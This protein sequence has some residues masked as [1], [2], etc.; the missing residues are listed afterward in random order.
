M[1]DISDRL[2]AEYA[3]LSPEAKAQLFLSNR[4]GTYAG[5]EVIAL[6]HPQAFPET[7]PQIMDGQ[8][9]F[10]SKKYFTKDLLSV[11]I[12]E[13]EQDGVPLTYVLIDVDKLKKIN[14]NLGH[15]A[16]HKVID[17][18]INLLTKSFRS[19]DRR[20]TVQQT[21]IEQRQ[22]PARK[23]P[24]KPDTIAQIPEYVDSGRVGFGDE[25]ALILYNADINSAKNAMRRFQ[26][27]L[28][29]LND[30]REVPFTV[31][32]GIAQYTSGAIPEQLI[33]Y[34]DQALYM[35]KKT[36]RNRVVIFGENPLRDLTRSQR[37][38]YNLANGVDRLGQRM[39]TFAETIR[40]YAFRNK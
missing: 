1:G 26:D 12:A 7:A 34:A 28:K 2:K 40:D 33:D 15:N 35:A 10:F 20:H 9:G 8:T 17:L 5:L 21:E 29:N 31:S 23:G 37:V 14:D 4:E 39:A 24:V 16:G 13:A 6:Q 18:L 38:A 32:I 19:Y 27:G 25:F 36:G 22:R 11:R 3:S 30:S